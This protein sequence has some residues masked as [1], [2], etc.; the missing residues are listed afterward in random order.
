MPGEQCP[1]SHITLP[2]Q[3]YMRNHTQCEATVAGAVYAQLAP[4]IVGPSWPDQGS[5]NPDA[6]TAHH[7]V[8]VFAESASALCVCA[9]GN[10]PAIT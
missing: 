2:A 9:W 6:S 7:N 1:V 5:L 10:T 3:G 4:G 8:P